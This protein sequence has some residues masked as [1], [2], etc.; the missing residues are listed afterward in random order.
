MKDYYNQNFVGRDIQVS[1]AVWMHDQ[2]RKKGLTPKLSRPWK[3][4]FVVIKKINDPVFR[5]QQTPR[6]KPKVLLC[7]R[8]WKYTE[9]NPPT[10]FNTQRCSNLSEHSTNSTNHEPTINLPDES[11]QLVLTSTENLSQ[12]DTCNNPTLPRRST[13][14]RHPRPVQKHMVTR[15]HFKN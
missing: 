1:D 3:G 9:A 11:E 7:N 4:P 5:I 15:L 2:Q 6:S 8:L 14:T 13:Q 10:W 12:E